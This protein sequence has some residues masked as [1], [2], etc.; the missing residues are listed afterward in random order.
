MAHVKSESIEIDGKHYLIGGH[1]KEIIGGPYS[2]RK[3]A[4][5]ASREASSLLGESSIE[6]Y[7]VFLSTG[8]VPAMTDPEWVTWEQGGS[9]PKIINKLYDALA[10]GEHSG[11]SNVW[12]P[13]NQ[14]ST[15]WGPVQL[16]VGP[17]R[18]MLNSGNAIGQG[19]IPLTADERDYLKKYISARD[20]GKTPPDTAKDRVLYENVTKKY[21]DFVWD[22]A[23]GDHKN[24][25]T[26][27][28]WGLFDNKGTPDTADD[29]LWKDGINTKKSIDVDDTRY[30]GYFDKH[31]GLPPLD[32]GFITTLGM[33]GKTRMNQLPQQLQGLLPQ[34]SGRVTDEEKRMA[35]SAIEKGVLLMLQGMKGPKAPSTDAALSAAVEVSMR[36]GLDPD[37][38]MG[39]Y[40]DFFSQL[41]ATREFTQ[42]DAARDYPSYTQYQPV[43]ATWD[44][45]RGG[46]R[47][48][49]GAISDRE[50]NL[51]LDILSQRPSPIGGNTGLPSEIS[52]RVGPE[53]TDEDLMNDAIQSLARFGHPLFPS[54][55]RAPDVDPSR[56]EADSYLERFK[57]SVAPF[58]RKTQ[59]LISDEEA[60]AF[61]GLLGAE[62]KEEKKPQGTVLNINVGAQ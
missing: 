36:T 20:K 46:M 40:N 6:D 2:S 23:E 19:I 4:D 8:S 5:D 60:A 39:G 54:W 62:E 28:R 57:E 31:F 48:T 22:V 42:P 17:A 38:L 21:I 25:A 43:S 10:K 35:D 44:K 37:M 1:K 49:K 7:K 59:G 45:A 55:N 56:A 47:G 14:G 41:H 11:K 51:F 33:Q 32:T 34:Q 13:N 18:D 30:W 27:W 16:L 12:V 24:F 29:E 15:A 61:T 58:F 50:H 3:E 53:R 9:A 52:N 26:L